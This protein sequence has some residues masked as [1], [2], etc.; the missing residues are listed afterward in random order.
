[1]NRWGTRPAF[2]LCLG[3]SRKRSQQTTGGLYRSC[4]YNWEKTASFPP[5][6]LHYL[7]GN[8]TSAW[9]RC[10]DQ[11][12]CDLSGVWL[13]GFRCYCSRY[14][15][16]GNYWKGWAGASACS[17]TQHRLK[18]RLQQISRK[19]ILTSIFSR[20]QIVRFNFAPV[21]KKKNTLRFLQTLLQ[22]YH[23]SDENLLNFRYKLKDN[24]LMRTPND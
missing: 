20:N 13:R 10:I 17:P 3:P 19:F 4:N 8:S 15:H 14:L 2:P 16:F 6:N 18:S 24:C 1:M 5:I 7:S 9:F 23:L 11:I 21:R 22:K 12:H